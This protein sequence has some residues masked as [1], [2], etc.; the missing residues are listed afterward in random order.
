MLLSLLELL[1]LLFCRHQLL[2]QHALLHGIA[3]LSATEATQ[4]EFTQSLEHGQ[5]LLVQNPV[6]AA[7]A[8]RSA[9]ELFV[10]AGRTSV[11]ECARSGNGVIG[12]SFREIP[13]VA[14][15]ELLRVREANATVPK[16]PSATARRQ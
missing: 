9:L 13:A 5:R 2:R 15:E 7:E 1:S 6:E 14:R 11:R 3:L 16:N 12:A 4:Q 8:F 10:Q